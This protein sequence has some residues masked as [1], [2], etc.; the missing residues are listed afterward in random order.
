MEY[1]VIL[2]GQQYPVVK[3]INCQVVSNV[4]VSICV[5]L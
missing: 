5:E 2:T 1:G 3:I 4:M